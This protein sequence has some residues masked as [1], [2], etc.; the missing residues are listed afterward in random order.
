M[1]AYAVNTFESM[2][3][4]L[5]SLTAMVSVLGG[6]SLLAVTTPQN[7]NI[8]VLSA[9]QFE[10]VRFSDSKEADMMHRAYRILASGDH[11]YHGHRVEAMHQI[12]KAADLLGLD[13]SGDDRDHE[14]QFLSDDRLRDARGLLQDV[15]GASEVKDQKRITEHL[16]SAIKEIDAALRDH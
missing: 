14:K 7:A 2:K 9:N 3:I 16:N 10:T 12:K 5:L 4:K 8:P 11:D 1:T 13:L 15:R 6:A